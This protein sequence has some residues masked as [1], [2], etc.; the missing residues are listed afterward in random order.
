MLALSELA[1][2]LAISVNDDEAAA[3][4]GRVDTTTGM[5]EWL[6]RHALTATHHIA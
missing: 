4:V 5:R 1:R 2:I 3:L 6:G